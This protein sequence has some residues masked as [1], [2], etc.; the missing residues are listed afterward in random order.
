VT[1]RPHDAEAPCPAYAGQW[2]RCI[3][4]FCGGANSTAGRDATS[5]T[6]SGPVVLRKEKA[7]V[8]SWVSEERARVTCGHQRRNS[9][10]IRTTGK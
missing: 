3:K 5:V 9:V 10:G 1:E 7:I 8:R 4:N 6:A 2:S